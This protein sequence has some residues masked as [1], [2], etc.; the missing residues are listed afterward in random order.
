MIALST[1][2]SL[3]LIMMFYWFDFS[4]LGGIF[5]VISSFLSFLF[6]YFSSCIHV[7]RIASLP[8]CF[9]SLPLPPFLLWDGAISSSFVPTTRSSTVS[10]GDFFYLR[11]NLD[12]CNI[13]SHFP[14]SVSLCLSIS[15]LILVTTPYQNLTLSLFAKRQKFHLGYTLRLTRLFSFLYYYWHV[16]V[17]S[18]SLSLSLSLS[19]SAV[20]WFIKL[21]VR[22]LMS[23]LDCN[24][25]FL[26]KKKKSARNISPGLFSILLKSGNICCRKKE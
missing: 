16:A 20:T 10:L 13:L 3:C 4:F 2:G 14:L 12:Y 25:N 9:F 18:P 24:D 8:F 15:S 22:S 5:Y 26:Y 1:G 21:T 19:Y 7:L 17:G 23:F 11:I 6:P